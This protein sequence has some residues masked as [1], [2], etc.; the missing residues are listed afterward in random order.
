MQEDADGADDDAGGADAADGGERDAGDAPAAATT[1]GGALAGSDTRSMHQPDRSSTGKQLPP[2]LLPDNP[3]EDDSAV[4]R[5]LQRVRLLQQND[6]ETEGDS[7]EAGDP[8]GMDANG[9][10][11]DGGSGEDKAK[12]Q[13]M[14]NAQMCRG[15]DPDETTLEAFAEAAESAASKPTPN[16]RLADA[17]DRCVWRQSR[18]G[19]TG[20]LRHLTIYQ[21]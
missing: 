8:E 1:E 18:A 11:A 10:G 4:E 6:A 2:D 19:P 13:G 9:E 20:H 12:Q 7:Q 15:D 21:K 3:L 5:W 14:A 16:A 17:G